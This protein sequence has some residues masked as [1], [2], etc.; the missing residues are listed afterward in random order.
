MGNICNSSNDPKSVLKPPSHGIRYVRGAQRVP[1]ITMSEE[2]SF[3]APSRRKKS[4]N[5][6]VTFSN[7]TRDSW[8]SV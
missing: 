2:P 4:H 3:V 7:F 1:V 8:D 5:K 6:S